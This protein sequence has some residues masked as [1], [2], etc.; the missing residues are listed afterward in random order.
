[1]KLT[2]FVVVLNTGVVASE[3]MSKLL[4]TAL[5]SSSEHA[6][7][8]QHSPLKTAQCKGSLTKQANPSCNTLR[9]ER[10]RVRILARSSGRFS[11][12]LHRLTTVI[13]QY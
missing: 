13:W 10:C 1:M 12:T 4:V 8:T 2:S 5:R 3:D 6:A 9:C 11:D 7:H